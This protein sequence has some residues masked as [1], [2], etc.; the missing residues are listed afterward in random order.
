[1]TFSWFMFFLVV[2]L[3]GLSDGYIIG[4][5]VGKQDGVNEEAMRHNHFNRM[6]NK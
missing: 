2:M 6:D 5:H 1:M 3:L 4:Y